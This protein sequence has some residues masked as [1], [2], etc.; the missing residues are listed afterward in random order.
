MQSRTAS[1]VILGITAIVFSR[2]MLLLIDDPEGPNLLVVGA[3]A[4]FD[5]AESGCLPV[6]HDVPFPFA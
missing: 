5:N 1:L 2:S 4:A 3:G 6:Q